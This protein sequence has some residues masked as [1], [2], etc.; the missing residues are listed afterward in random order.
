M[1]AILV[2]CGIGLYGVLWL[3]HRLSGRTFLFPDLRLLWLLT[4][5]ALSYAAIQLASD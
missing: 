3:R 2:Y 5:A 1:T 4:L